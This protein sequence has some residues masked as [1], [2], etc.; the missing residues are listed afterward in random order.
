MYVEQ[1]SNGRLRDVERR[2]S[3]S[4]GIAAHAHAPPSNHNFESQRVTEMFMPRF[5]MPRSP[6]RKRTSVPGSQ[7]RVSSITG[8][9]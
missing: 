8:R 4:S 2:W 1:E 7:Q 6:A 5:F 9:R 3:H